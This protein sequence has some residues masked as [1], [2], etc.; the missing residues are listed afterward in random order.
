MTAMVGDGPEAWTDI[1]SADRWDGFT[2]S[3]FHDMESQDSPHKDLSENI[4]PSCWCG[5]RF[6]D[7]AVVGAR[8]LFRRPHGKIP[9][10]GKGVAGRLRFFPLMRAAPGRYGARRAAMARCARQLRLSHNTHLFLDNSIEEM[11][12]WR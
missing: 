4:C 8:S 5:Q 7:H 3:I 12:N 1:F 6:C 2:L 9:M 11:T 10:P